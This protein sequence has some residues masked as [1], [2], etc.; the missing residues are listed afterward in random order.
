MTE[1]Q[2]DKG[3]FD[4]A[5]FAIPDAAVLAA[6]DGRVLLSNHSHPDDFTIYHSRTY[7]I[8]DLGNF[9]LLQ[10]GPDTYTLYAHLR[11]EVPAPVVPGQEVPAGTRIGRQ[12]NT[13]NSNGPHLHFAVVDIRIFPEPAF[14]P[15]P[16]SGWGFYEMNGT[17]TLIVNTQYE[18]AN[19]PAK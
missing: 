15:K 8:P 14:I 1:D 11:H 6:A 10:H 16:R 4:F 2:P 19:V 5:N 17:N 7:S 9:V 3:A 12:G 18:S 13:G